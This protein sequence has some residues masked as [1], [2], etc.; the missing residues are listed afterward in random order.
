[1]KRKI[2]FFFLLLLLIA[3][4]CFALCHVQANRSLL[5]NIRHAYAQ[6][7]TASSSISFSAEQDM[8]I[9]IVFRS[10]LSR[11]TLS[12]ALH[13]AQGEQI[14]LLDQA[15]MLETYCTLPM[16]G[17]Y[18]LTADCSDMAGSYQVAVFSAVK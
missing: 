14:L 9:K 13:N 8:R 11:G 2:L 17:T 15:R 1:M 18:T 3:C 16:A 4:A 5:G 10:E 7:T 6:P 12:V